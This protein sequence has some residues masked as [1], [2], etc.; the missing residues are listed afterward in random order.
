MRTVLMTTS[1]PWSS[2]LGVVVISSIT[3]WKGSDPSGRRTG[4]CSFDAS[5]VHWSI[6][7]STLRLSTGSELLRDIFLADRITSS[8]PRS[9]LP[10]PLS[11]SEFWRRLRQPSVISLCRQTFGFL[12]SRSLWWRWLL[13]RGDPLGKRWWRWRRSGLGLSRDAGRE[14]REEDRDWW[15][16]FREVSCST[17]LLMTGCF[18]RDSFRNRVT[19]VVFTRSLF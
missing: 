5:K 6:K 10:W 4:F 9:P 7:E 3:A 2:F 18:S 14:E 15:D 16:S 19:V 17:S 1:A 13:N 12:T 8:F 11:S